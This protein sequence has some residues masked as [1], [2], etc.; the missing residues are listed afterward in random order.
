MS[1]SDGSSLFV[2]PHLDDAV[3]SCGRL[4]AG[5]TGVTVVT[6]LAGSPDRWDEVTGWDQACG[7]ATGDDVLAARLSEDRA[8][9]RILGARQR[10]INGLDDQYGPQPGRPGLV[11]DGIESALADLAPQS[12][13]IP[14]GLQHPDHI[15][16]RN[17]A[18]LVAAQAP[19]PPVWTV[20][21]DL[22]YGRNDPGGQ[23]HDEAF[24]AYAEAGFRLRELQPDLD[25]TMPIKAAAA[26]CYVSQLGAMRRFSPSFDR[27]IESERYWALERP[28]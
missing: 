5:L 18:L 17:V 12:C 26:E 21:E 7:F 16:V 15:E 1:E 19:S 11:R 4:M 14:L 28:S 23:F 10:T 13:A 27:D 9:L 20:Y 3:L 8:A 6:A 24:A 2:S 22:P 25:S